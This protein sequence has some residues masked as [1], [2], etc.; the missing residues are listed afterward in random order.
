MKVV[1]AGLIFSKIFSTTSSSRLPVVSCF[2][3]LT[4][5]DTFINM[6]S[7][8]YEKCA[9]ITIKWWICWRLSSVNYIDLVFFRERNKELMTSRKMLSRRQ[10]AVHFLL[11]VKVTS[12]SQCARLF[13]VSCC[14]QHKINVVC[15]MMQ[16]GQLFPQLFWYNDNHLLCCQTTVPQLFLNSIL[17]PVMSCVIK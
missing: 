6:S 14:V 1:E 2:W 8:C 4:S 12:S 11:L 9:Y 7:F 16:R 5:G 15:R 17:P 10:Q 3:V 13:A